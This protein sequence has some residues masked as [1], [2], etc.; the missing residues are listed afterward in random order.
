MFIQA[1]KYE[2]VLLTSKI[3]LIL[4]VQLQFLYRMPD[5]SVQQLLPHHVQSQRIS[6]N[7]KDLKSTFSFL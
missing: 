1:S 3:T 5:V 2:T 6:K 7:F 4:F